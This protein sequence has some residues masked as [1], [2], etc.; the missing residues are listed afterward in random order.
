[1][2]LTEVIRSVLDDKLIGEET[3]LD[4]VN[5]LMDKFGITKDQAFIIVYLWLKWAK[6]IEGPISSDI[7]L[8]PDEADTWE[9]TVKHRNKFIVLGY[10]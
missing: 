2:E 1:M 3:N 8:D 10:I 6:T 4:H 5:H 9:V 7:H